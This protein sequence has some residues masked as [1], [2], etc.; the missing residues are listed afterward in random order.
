M[1]M[2]MTAAG[3][4]ERGTPLVVVWRSGDPPAHYRPIVCVRMLPSSNH[5]RVSACEPEEVC[6]PPG[7]KTR[8]AFYTL[9]AD[10]SWRPPPIDAGLERHQFAHALES[11]DQRIEQLETRNRKLASMRKA[12]RVGESAGP[13]CAALVAIMTDAGVTA[14]K[15]IQAAARL[16]EYKTPSDLADAAKLYLASVFEDC[17]ANVDDRLLAAAALRKAEDVKLVPITERPAPARVDPVDEDYEP[18]ADRVTR[19]RAR[20][21]VLTGQIAREYG[22]EAPASDPQTES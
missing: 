18:L 8:R 13:A 6:P 20:A 19:Q 7:A 21:D 11:K 17:D 14:R 9:S 3:M 22:Y 16:L 4:T 1:V 15:R 12:I 5:W 10:G 2:V